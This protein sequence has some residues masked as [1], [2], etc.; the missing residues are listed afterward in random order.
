MYLVNVFKRF[1]K[2]FAQLFLTFLTVFT[3]FLKRFLHQWFK[4]MLTSSCLK[5]GGTKSPPLVY[6]TVLSFSFPF[7]HCVHSP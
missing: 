4:H 6:A 1:I 7:F 5:V 3:I 2:F